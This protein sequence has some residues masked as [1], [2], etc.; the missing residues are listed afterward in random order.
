MAYIARTLTSMARGVVQK[1]GLPA[2]TTATTSTCRYL[3]TRVSNPPTQHTPF[4]AQLTTLQT[5]QQHTNR[6]RDH[7]LASFLLDEIEVEKEHQK[8][9]PKLAGFRLSQSGTEVTLTQKSGDERITV[10]FD[11]NQSVNVDSGLPEEGFDED[12]GTGGVIT[13]YPEFSITIEKRSG[14]SLRF[15]CNTE[16]GEEVDE[17]EGDVGGLNIISVQAFTSEPDVDVTKIYE[18]EAENMD[19]NLHDMLLDTLSERGLDQEFVDGLIDLSTV[20]EHRMYVDHL[21][22]LRDFAEE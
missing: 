16:A 2:S 12:E 6:G 5:R 20:V 9:V 17:G 13:S 3:S 22:R 1:V 15:N 19:E 10:S 4:I 18:A 21:E 8:A 11:V 14:R 7:D